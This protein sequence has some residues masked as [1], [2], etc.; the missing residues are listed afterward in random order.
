MKIVHTSDW[1]LGHRFQEQS[2][3]EEQLEFLKWLESYINI[4]KIDVLLIA[5]DVFDT[6]VP[7]SQSQKLYYDFLVKLQ[8]S[9]C[10][11]IVITGGNH[12]A[13]GTLNAPKALLNALS[14]HVIGK[15][16]DNIEDEVLSLSVGSENVTIAG[17]PYLRDR[18]IRKAVAG[19]SFDQLDDRYK[20]A[21]INHYQS[22]ADSCKDI[23]T[24]APII[25]MGHLFAVGGKTSDS[26]QSIYIGNLGDIGVNDFPEIFDYIALGHLH[27]PQIIAKNEKIRYSGSPY[28]LS[29]SEI[30]YSK[31][32]VIIETDSSSIRK[33]EE[34]EIPRF[35]KIYK[36]SGNAEDRMSKLREIDRKKEKLTPW[37]EVVLDVGEN[38]V[39]SHR[40]IKKV[41]E[42]L[43]LDVLKITLG[44][45]TTVSDIKELMKSSKHVK[46]LSPVDVFKLK[47][48]EEHF[49]LEEECEI[50]DAFNEILQIVRDHG[51]GGDAV[52]Q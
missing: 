42:D 51:N 38:R 11:H 41:A 44:N 27:R 26:E 35:R 15:V 10:K 36:V 17:V 24:T 48:K 34:I 2:Q 45:M 46:E 12:D 9:P 50:K 14:I 16:T 19:E 1:H 21:L 22:V 37:V 33:V 32:I 25:A 23:D 43:D 3:Y 5:G 18:D 47:C 31:K 40:E 6:G 8:N 20:T 39:L 13:P 4:N 49:E 29:F 28:I 7:S 30:N 52:M